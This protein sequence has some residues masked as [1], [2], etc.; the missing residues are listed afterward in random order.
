[1]LARMSLLLRSD[2]APSSELPPPEL[3][4]RV[5]GIH[6]PQMF[7]LEGLKG[8]AE[9]LYGAARHLDGRSPRRL[10][11]WGCGCGRVTAHLLDVTRGLE[12]LGCDI[13]R[14]AVAWCND[15]LQ[16][17]AFEAIAPDPPTPYPDSSFDLIFGYS[18]FTHLTRAAQ[19]AWLEELRRIVSPQG[20]VVVSVHGEFATSFHG[21]RATAE[22]RRAGI[23]DAN[24]DAAFDGIAPDEYY[25][26]TF[27]SRRYTLRTWREQFEILDYSE[28]GIGN[29]QDLVVMRPRW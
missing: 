5:V 12:I 25:R 19:R 26:A 15:K 27:Q 22:L 21:R 7:Q 8:A 28:R 20:L 11:E 17:G 2:L 14:E 23:L 6:N 29:L 24:R 16:P 1:A 10:L 3:R 13:D 9:L 18:V 4:E